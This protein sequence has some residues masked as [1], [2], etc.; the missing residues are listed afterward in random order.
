MCTD[1]DPVRQLTAAVDALVA[2]DP[3]ALGDGEAVVALHRQLSRLEA[4]ATRAS[5]SFGRSGEWRADGARTPVA[6]LSARCRLPER[7]ARRRV[8]LGRALDHLPV[9]EGA[10]LAG[11]IGSP[12]VELLVRARND[13]T[14]EVLAEHEA[15]LVGHARMLHP[16]SFARV[17]AYWRQGADPEGVEDEAAALHQARRVHLSSSFEGTWF[18]DG[19]LDPVGGE[20]LAGALREIEEELFRSD[21]AEARAE[22]GEG[23]T[24][25]HL[26][27]SGPQRRADALVELARRG[28]AVPKG[29]R[30]R[31]P[32]FTVHVDHATLAGRI[33]ELARSRA[34]VSPESLVPWLADAD[35][36]RVVFDG[37][38]R[39]L[40][41][42]ARRRFFS[43]ADR[44]AVEVRDLECTSPGCDVPAEDCEVD[45]VV[46]F[47]EGGP[48]VAENGRLACGFH[49]RL[50][51]GATRP[52]RGPP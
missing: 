50:R 48:T 8:A 42:G 43:G 36:E 17:V 49:N 35:V 13:A 6:W 37:G 33:C 52:E 15:D 28:T 46:P 25:E 32:L 45:H 24:V 20:V 47:A 4:V 26:R 44:R 12:A 10:W 31:R 11:E 38:D 39:V 29:A 9:A 51:P 22:H 19:V 23:A 14:A 1:G 30:A 18:L 7:T 27:R 3:A 5:A 21:W 40:G 2:A 34:A 16:R 41:V